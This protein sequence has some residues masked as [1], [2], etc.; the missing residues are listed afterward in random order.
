MNKNKLIDLHHHLFPPKFEAHPWDV[1]TDASDMEKLGITG[2][3]L[4]CPVPMLSSEVRKINEYL[5]E[6]SDFR[7]D[8]YG[9]LASIPFDDPQAALE[10]IRYA[11]DELQCDGFCVSSNNHD[12]YI[13]DDSLDPVFEELNRRKAV[14]F[15]HPSPRRASGYNLKLTGS[16]DSAYEYVF[17][18]TRAMMDF[19]YKDKMLKTPDIKWIVSH[20]G[21]TIPYLSHRLSHA[22]EWRAAQQPYEVI[23]PQ[24]QS[25]YY[26][27]AMANDPAVYEMLKA[28]AGCKHVVFGTDYPPHK[29]PHI[30]RDI[31]TLNGYS[32]YS[33]DEK[34][35]VMAGNACELFPRF[36]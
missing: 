10:E 13:S 23:Y 11:C 18:T 19:I 6:S 29:A 35:K 7:P 28:V 34:E 31:E 2:V 15:L 24:I 4:S 36:K 33:E 3:M 30:K 16:M 1:K 9:F 26:D 12:I 8:Q 22:S 27:T 25:L 17:E 20:A 5:K 32:G 14:V 21:G